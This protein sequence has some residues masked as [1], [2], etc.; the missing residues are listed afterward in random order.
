MTD[1]ATQINLVENAVTTIKDIAPYFM[2]VVTGA[3]IIW[4]IIRARSAH[5][6]I[7]KIWR[8]IGGGAINDP[9]LKK[10]WMTIRDMEAFRFRTGIK[11]NTTSSWNRT[12]RW[13]EHNDKSL[14]DLSFARAWIFNKPW[15]F[16]EPWTGW[17]RFNVSVV[18]L[19]L[20]PLLTGMVYM[21]NS[22][23]AL[24]T[25]KASE[26]TFWTDGAVATDF[27]LARDTPAF[28]LDPQTCKTK[29]IA[30]L[31]EADREIICSSMEKNTQPLIENAMKLQK[32]YSAYLGILCIVALFMAARY[33][34]R[35]QMAK[36]FYEL[37]PPRIT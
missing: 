21:F 23:S 7:D 30:G 31:A 37:K 8:L 10:E 5:F 13:L 25:I 9:D 11:F 2:T 36:I 34:A 29:P 6:L 3:L 28:S 22:P 4:A 12:L 1:T 18:F 19:T 17:I 24:L 33:T 15:D 27:W 26:V 32:Y 14:S 35:A 20:A 16:K